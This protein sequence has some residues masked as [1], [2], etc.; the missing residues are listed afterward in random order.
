MNN[1]KECGTSPPST[2][3]RRQL[4]TIDE[5][6]EYLR[7]S[8]GTIYKHVRT[9]SFPRVR[10][11]GRVLY[12]LATV[13]AW[14]DKQYETGEEIAEAKGYSQHGRLPRRDK[15]KPVVFSLN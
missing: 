6:A 5:L 10:I 1:G 7:I 11:F 8:K 13:H 2:I 4:L 12:D 9:G 3:E 15:N 14:L